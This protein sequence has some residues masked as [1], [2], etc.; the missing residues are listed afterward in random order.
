MKRSTIVLFLVIIGL[1]VAPFAAS[2]QTAPPGGTPPGSSGGG[3]SSGDLVTPLDWADSDGDG[4]PNF[5]EPYLAPL[6]GN[7]GCNYP[8]SVVFDPTS[9]LLDFHETMP[10]SGF[11]TIGTIDMHCVQ[12]D[13]PPGT[14][15]HWFQVTPKQVTPWYRPNVTN[16]PVVYWSYEATQQQVFYSGVGGVGML[17]L[18]MCATAIEPTLSAFNLLPLANVH[19]VAQAICGVTVAFVSTTGMQQALQAQWQLFERLALNSAAAD[20]AAHQPPSLPTRMLT[21]YARAAEQAYIWSLSITF[22]GP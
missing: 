15:A 20:A 14:E 1:L 16:P 13:A 3:S 9:G 7:P 8:A 4:I 21:M 19:P 12:T 22:G 11:G 18:D 5:Y 2:A 10:G 6:I 17:R